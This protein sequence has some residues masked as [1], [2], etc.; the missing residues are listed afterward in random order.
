MK[1]FN[2]TR[3]SR[4]QYMFL[5][6]DGVKRH[7]DGSLAADA[8]IVHNTREVADFAKILIDQGYKEE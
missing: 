1:T 3:V 7:N 6:Y 8:K 4:G 5:Y 2:W